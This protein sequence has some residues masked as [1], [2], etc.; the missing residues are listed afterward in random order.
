MGKISIH[1]SKLLKQGY[2]SRKLQTTVRKLDG[3]QTFLVQK[4]D[5]SVSHMLKDLF[6]NCDT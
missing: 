2:S 5:T 3:R 1:L 6:A 4:F